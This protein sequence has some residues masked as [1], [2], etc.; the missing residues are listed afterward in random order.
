MSKVLRIFLDSNFS[1]ELK[2]DSEETLLEL[3]EKVSELFKSQNIS[4]I[5]CSSGSLVV[6][7]SK[8]QAILIEDLNRQV[9]HQEN[10]QEKEI[11]EN[12]EELSDE[13]GQITEE[14]EES[15]EEDDFDAG[16]IK[17]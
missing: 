3:S 14:I 15:E 17:D 7:P 4:V 5:H 9:E 2:D 16:I 11:K 10:G 1:I 8:V 6:R 12:E 13:I